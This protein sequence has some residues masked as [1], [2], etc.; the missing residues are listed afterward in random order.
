M[1]LQLKGAA[2][3]FEVFGFHAQHFR[4]QP[5]NIEVGVIVVEVGAIREYVLLRRVSMQVD[6]QGKVVAELGFQLSS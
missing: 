5:C 4:Q 6:K 3:I 2:G 1:F